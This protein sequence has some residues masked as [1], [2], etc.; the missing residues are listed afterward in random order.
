MAEPIN[1][2]A[3]AKPEAAP[4]APVEPTILTLLA[5]VNGDDAS[6]QDRDVKVDDLITLSLGGKPV[7]EDVKADD[8]ASTQ[9]TT[10][11]RPDNMPAEINVRINEAQLVHEPTGAAQEFKID[12]A[13][14]WTLR[15]EQEGFSSNILTI[16]A[17]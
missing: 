17:S 3:I 8:G 6:P 1:A 16:I 4:Q 9:H 5:S 11:P 13:G 2:S 14:K 15:V 12:V 7:T 10:Y